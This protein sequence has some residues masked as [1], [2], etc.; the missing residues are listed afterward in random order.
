MEK[1]L[2]LNLIIDHNCYPQKSTS[3]ASN[4]FLTFIVQFIKNMDIDSNL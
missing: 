4:A 2:G 3:E 1:W